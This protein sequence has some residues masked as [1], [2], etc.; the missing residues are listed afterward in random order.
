MQNPDEAD[1]DNARSIFEISPNPN[2]GAFKLKLGADFL[3]CTLT[4][5]QPNGEII[6]NQKELSAA[7]SN[8]V[9]PGMKSG[10]YI[11]EVQTTTKKESKIMLVK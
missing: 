5:I 10:A 7:E 11:V 4:I 1:S 9:V 3:P 2:N 6:W 8:I